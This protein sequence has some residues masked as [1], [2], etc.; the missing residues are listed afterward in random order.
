[1]I[2]AV[3]WNFIITIHDYEGWLSIYLH[4]WIWGRDEKKKKLKTMPKFLIQTTEWRGWY[5]SLRYQTH[6]GK[7]GWRKMELGFRQLKLSLRHYGISQ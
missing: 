7:N 1:M 4:D 6:R 5:H 2:Y 3:L